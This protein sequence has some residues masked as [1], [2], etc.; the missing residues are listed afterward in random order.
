M[1]KTVIALAA[2]LALPGA[3]LADTAA[4]TQSEQPAAC[5]TA[6]SDLDCAA[7]GSIE[8]VRPAS[9]NTATGGKKL[10]IDVDP[11]SISNGM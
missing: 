7:T 9:D 10:G 4:K 6:K 5:V 2:L 1:K 8:K 3:A 11:W